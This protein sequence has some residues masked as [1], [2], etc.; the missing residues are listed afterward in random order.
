MVLALTETQFS[1]YEITSF[2]LYEHVN[3]LTKTRGSWIS[4]RVED[5]ASTTPGSSP[6][7]C[8]IGDYNPSNSP[9][10][11]WSSCMDQ[12]G[13]SFRLVSF[14]GPTDFGLEIKHEYEDNSQ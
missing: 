12:P 2:H 13:F 11:E 7:S 9:L 4:F 3:K 14:N 5:K 1:P 8:Q 10:E 6:A